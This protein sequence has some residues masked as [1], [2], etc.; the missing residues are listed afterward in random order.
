LVKEGFASAPSTASWSVIPGG[1]PTRFTKPNLK[2]GLFLA[3]NA[4]S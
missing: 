4:A 1:Q 3:K 2:A